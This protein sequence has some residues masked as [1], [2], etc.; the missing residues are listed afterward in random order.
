VANGGVAS[1]ENVVGSERFRDSL[2]G[3]ARGNRLFG[4]GGNDVID[5]RA[6]DDVIVGGRGDDLL[7]GGDG[8]DN[9]SGEEGDDA[10][11]GGLADDV[12]T[13]NDGDDQLAG[14]AG[15][16]VL[17]GGEG[18]D[19]LA[20]GEG[21]DRLGGDAGDDYLVGEDGLDVLAGGAGEDT[22]VGGAGDDVLAGEAGDDLLQ[23]DE[24]DD[25]YIF[26]AA[27]G[28]DR[29]VDASG[30]NATFITGVSREN[31]WL[32]RVGDDLSIA[33]IGGDSTITIDNYYAASGA[34][35]MRQVSLESESLFLRYAEP[36]IAAMSAYD[37]VPEMM[38]AEIAAL[39]DD[40]W[41]PAGKAEPAVSDIAVATD[42]DTV[43]AGR[44]EAVDQ[45]E[46]ITG[47]DVE[48]QAAHGAVVIDAASGV[49]TYTP[50]ANYHGADVFLLR[51]TDAD[52]FTA[53]Q[54]VD[55]T[56]RSVNDAPDGIS[57]NGVT[58]IAERDRPP[59]GTVLEAVTI[60]VLTASDVDA[61]DD[62]DFASH[63]FSVA[64]SRFEIV[65]NELR[66]RAGAAL[67]FET[68]TSVSVDI[69][70]TDRN[71][72]GLSFTRPFTFQVLD[73]DD[74]FIGTAGADTLV[75]TAGRNLLFG[76]NGDDTLTGA[77]ANDSI[78]GGDGADVLR[79]L[80][81]NDLLDG[82]LGN[83]SL[84]AGD[85]DD[86]ALGGD[87]D[88]RVLGAAGNDQL[89]G[90]GGADLLYGGTG[91]DALAGGADNDLLRGEEGNDTVAGDAGDDVLFGDAGADSLSGGAGFDTVTYESATEGVSVDLARAIGTR[92]WAQGDVF[93]D[94]PERLVG[95]GFAD[96]LTGSA[97][98]DRLEGGAG[99]DTILGGAGNDSLLGGDGND[100][101]DAQ[102]GND[103]LMGGAGDDILIGGDDSDTY[104]LDVNSGADEIRNYD[105]NGTDIDV[106]GYAAI[107]REQLWF[108]RS[109]NHLIVSV[110]GTGVRTMIRDWYS[111][112]NAQD[113]ANHKIDFFLAS[114]HVSQT[115][116]AEGLVAL[117]SGYQQ[118]QTQA[119]YD[120]LLARSEFQAPWA[121][122][123]R[124][125]APPVVAEILPQRIREDG[126]LSLT[127][128]ITD[129]FTPAAGISVTARAVRL[130][131]PDIEDLGIVNAPT[132]SAPNGAGQRVLTVTT[133][134]N[135]SGQ[136]GIRIRA[137]DAGGL[138]QERLFTLTID[139]VADA[140]TLQLV[141]GPIVAPPL[142]KLTFD[143]GSLPLNLQ[144]AL[145][146]QDGSET[147]EVRIANVPAG[148]T[149]SSGSN[150]GDGVWS[151]TPA[152]LPGLRL[153]AAADWA[154][155]LSFSITAIS[156]ETATG[157]VAS[158]TPVPLNLEINARPTDI[159]ADG[160]LAVNENS[161]AG[162]AVLT[163]R[164]VDADASD[165][166]RFELL[167]NAEGRF[168]IGTDGRLVTGG[169]ALDFERAAS[170]TITVRV[171]DSGGLSRTED[172]VVNVN[173]V[174][175]APTAINVD[176]TLTFSEGTAAGAL[177]AQFSADDP[178]RNVQ[179]F[180]LLDSL[181]GRFAISQSGALTLGPTRLDFES[182][183]RH[184][185][186]VR[187]TD[188]GGLSR[189]QQFTVNVTDQNEAPSLAARTF[190]INEN[191]PGANQIVVGTVTATDPD[192]VGPN[193]SLTYRAVGG[194]TNVFSVNAAGEV[195]YIGETAFGT[196]R[197][198]AERRS[199]YSLQ[200][201]ARDGGGMTSVNTVTINVNNV[202]VTPQIVG[203][204]PLVRQIFDLGNFTRLLI[205]D[206]DDD[207]SFDGPLRYTAEAVFGPDGAPVA[208]ERDGP[209]GPAGDSW[210][211]A[212]PVYG[213]GALFR[214]GG[215]LN[216]TSYLVNQTVRV[217]VEDSASGEFAVANIRLVNSTVSLFPVA[218]DLDG[219]GLELHER[220]Q[221]ALFDM[222]GDG[223][224]DA[225][226]W[227]G[228][229]D[230]FLALDRDGDGAIT[231]G[232]EISFAQDRDGAL[233]DLDGL[234]AYD[235][236]GNMAFDALDDRYGDFVVWRDAN[237]DGI[238]QQG[239]LQSLAAHG[240]ES[241]SLLRTLTGASVTD[242]A[243]N[244][245]T[246]TSTLRRTDST[247]STVGDV[248]LSYQTVTAV[249]EPVEFADLVVE[250]EEGNGNTESW[251]AGIG[252]EERRADVP[253]DTTALSETPDDDA[254]P[255]SLPTSPQPAQPDA[256]SFSAVEPET[257]PPQ[258][259]AAEQAPEPAM[260]ESSE[261]LPQAA[262]ASPS[263][264]HA[265][266]DLISRR[267]LQM[268]EA[269][270]GFAPRDSAE[271]SLQPQRSIDARTLQL[272]T[273]IPQ[274]K[275]A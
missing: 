125:N 173:N 41:Q 26:D 168:A 58:A 227:I 84:D 254:D 136:V 119:E 138:V 33:V 142:T 240:I 204:E 224:L 64:D 237:Q 82:G 268:I 263:A 214:M 40:F 233:S 100:V 195:R 112:T 185:I 116:D 209:Y 156:R 68:A 169:T 71:G 35:T 212:A 141:Q 69:T 148:I 219:D 245:V 258:E 270:A 272:L 259:R 78:E 128:T 95:S 52:G 130:D 62:G 9:L 194:D 18:G 176:R 70:V 43:L 85:G 88:D 230:A 155:D 118:P 229:D 147:L 210:G 236:N 15:A 250:R 27:S 223:S 103:M 66:L 36:L 67:D 120:A 11:S 262:Q 211:F 232:S 203:I 178:E 274:M 175:E 87:G 226:G 132:I 94:T 150:R 101:L 261:W 184:T 137:V 202:D 20:G 14:D 171:T 115:I 110:I 200:V 160:P 123:W 249:V 122:A 93:I 51:V 65:G 49:W 242:S 221:N 217:R 152:Q 56:V 53:T 75:G 264:L 266:L 86:T 231:N 34:S 275:V 198:W 108:S 161:A 199:S 153:Q 4:L 102:S 146:D 96:E 208:I 63:V 98:D 255:I 163:L 139:P 50:A 76:F 73:R 190:S 117:M 165:S 273:S 167:S 25:A 144:A 180:T 164:R 42:E 32:R 201:E 61:P 106:V 28:S 19:A 179:S 166:A 7:L 154:Q 151:F 177:L 174:N 244:V 5:G 215:S 238:S 21:D 257:A 260:L 247:R 8:A 191:A 114:E 31:L 81:G 158:S 181:G 10:L 157:E 39:L 241:I 267:R 109:G 205:V 187:A 55:V 121:Q 222:N 22:L 124:L 17:S 48:V 196:G 107:T 30:R 248:A 126:T 89:S 111:L 13:G 207:L 1:I 228:A 189:E 29:I 24:G 3:D 113:R 38:P 220:N 197:L 239:E 256:A 135:A 59:L 16:D 145:A 182:N 193:S 54:R 12:I 170:H 47:Y 140:P 104:M 192:R 80:A 159:V 216:F 133:R 131:N 206:P 186:T 90:N 97:G 252:D 183:D 46:N 246:A 225:G 172:F 6:G 99:D 143:G 23:G 105:P 218:L 129:D 57:L 235:S 251:D 271:L 134:P 213:G 149:F 45:D 188:A 37:S 74:H 92:G 77:G 253:A 44:V 60:G 72:A 162:T 2:F 265:N 269:M 127:A 83:D 79:G 91:D 234:A 243:A